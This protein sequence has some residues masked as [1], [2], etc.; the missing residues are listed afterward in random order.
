MTWR[1]RELSAEDE[2]WIR[3]QVAKAPP[4]SDRQRAILETLLEGLLDRPD[5]ASP[6]ANPWPHTDSGDCIALGRHLTIERRKQ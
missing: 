2:A 5:A 3:E 1:S 4:V 6:E